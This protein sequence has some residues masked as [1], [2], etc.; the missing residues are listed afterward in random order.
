MALDRQRQKVLYN[1]CDP[2]ESVGPSDKRCVDLD[3]NGGR[4][5]DVGE[6]WVGK[7]ATEIELADDRTFRLIS[8]LPGSG[9]SSDLRRLKERLEAPEPDSAPRFLTVIVDAEEALDLRTSI[10]LEQLLVV[11]VNAAEEAVLAREQEIGVNAGKKPTSQDGGVLRLV[12]KFFDLTPSVER[13]EMSAG[14][15]RVGL[16]LRADEGLRQK[17]HQLMAN[18]PAAFLQQVAE[19]LESLQNRA[20]QA[21]SQGLVLIVDS[22]E[23]LRGLTHNFAEV[24]NSA[25]H[26]FGSGAPHLRLPVSVIYTVPPALVLRLSEPVRQLPMIKLHTRDGAPY[27]P[28]I[29]AAR[30]LI[31]SRIPDED[32]A[33][34]LGPGAEG[35][36]AIHSVIEA[37][38]GYPRELV[39]L[40]QALIARG[41]FPLS[42]ERVRR[43]VSEISDA[44]RRVAH[45]EGEAAIVLL[46]TIHRTKRLQFGEAERH[47]VDR[48]IANNLILR[49]Q[50]DTDWVDVHP[51]LL[52][53]GAVAEVIAKQE[54]AAAE[55]DR[56]E[57]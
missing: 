56:P 10:R 3:E 15:G 2:N 31:R 46:A 44:Y 54:R 17:L 24:L 18:N 20:V 22:L 23:K 57:A 52:T 49:Y 43:T 14:F 19:A 42:A 32:L 1:L 13:V 37:S 48:L 33:E 8:G 7:L 53:H 47:L 25:E 12:T 40:L 28:G 29:D 35:E 16:G 51:A 55:A 9:K 36:A 11:L 26:L 50:N 39:R 45:S 34:I 6:D 38:G 5:L 21:G 41:N 4:G 27:Q 30:H